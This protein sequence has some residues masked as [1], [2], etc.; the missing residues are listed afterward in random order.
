VTG[1]PLPLE[2]LGDRNVSALKMNLKRRLRNLD[3]SGSFFNL[4]KH[5]IKAYLHDNDKETAEISFQKRSL[6]I[7]YAVG[8][9]GA[10]KEVGEQ[11]A[12]SLA[13]EIIKGEIKL[14]LVA[15]TRK[16]LRDYFNGVKKYIAPDSEN[17]CIIWAED[18]ESYF[19]L[20]NQSLQTTDI[21]WT[22]PSELS[23]YCALGIPIIMTPA[24]G[25]QEKCNRRWLREIGA[26]IKQQD[27]E[28]ANQWLFDMLNRGR[29]AEAAWNGFLKARK[30]GT[31]NIIDFLESGSFISSND[32]LKR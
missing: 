10:Q 12:Q 27:P 6:T 29:L 25:P 3:P 21:L 32:P 2:L 26:G 20:F 30:Y 17:V 8:G 9:A 5:S 31:Y 19:D 28:F 11:I 1:F 15:G 22:K 16:E 23:F 14:N 7:T 4:Y 24:I 18:N 13:D